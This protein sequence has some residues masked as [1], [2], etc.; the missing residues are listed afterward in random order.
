VLAASAEPANIKTVTKTATPVLTRLATSGRDVSRP[1]G[2]LQQANF[3]KPQ[4]K[5][6]YLHFVKTANCR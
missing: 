5:R 2:P 3:A 6:V 1:C 4:P